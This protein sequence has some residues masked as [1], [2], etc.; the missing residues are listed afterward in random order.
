MIGSIRRI[1]YK[2]WYIQTRK[3]RKV[4][5]EFTGWATREPCDDD[6]AFA[7]AGNDVYGEFGDTEIEV[8]EK[9]KL[10]LDGIG[11]VYVG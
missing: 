11:I 7:F 2:D 8:I 6:I 4:W 5:H 9:L 10:E 1:R 3:C